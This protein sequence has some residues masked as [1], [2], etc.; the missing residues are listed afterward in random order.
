MRWFAQYALKN[1]NV[2]QKR[3]YMGKLVID[4]NSI[5]E[6][7]E[8]CVKQR[9]LPKECQVYE[10]LQEEAEKENKKLEK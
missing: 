7:D 8:E 5:Y 10:Y 1:H 4:G 2:K 9:K 3:C 6:I